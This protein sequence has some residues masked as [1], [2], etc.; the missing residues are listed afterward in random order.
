MVHV[1]QVGNPWSISS[2]QFSCADASYYVRSLLCATLLVGSVAVQCSSL[3]SF[4]TQASSKPG[5]LK[6][7]VLRPHFE[8]GFLGEPLIYSLDVNDTCK[9]PVSLQ[10]H[11]YLVC[12]AHLFRDP[13]WVATHSLGSPVLNQA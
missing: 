1:P 6:L 8:K 7:F 4:I 2:P 11:L 10:K 13:K 3:T 12:Q 9:R 5:L